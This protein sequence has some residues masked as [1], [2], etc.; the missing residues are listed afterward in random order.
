MKKIL[1][2]IIVLAVTLSIMPLAS[3]C[4]NAYLDKAPDSGLSEEEVFSKY[5]N[6]KSFFYA[7]YTGTNS[8]LRAFHPL[9]FAFNNKKFTFEGI[10]DMCDMARLTDSQ[11]IKM[12]NGNN[13]IW[14]VGYNTTGGGNKEAAKVTYA[15]RILRICN[16]AI[17]KID[18]LQ[19]A[20]E[21]QKED[22]LGQAYFVRAYVN[23]EIFRF[24][25]AIPYVDKVLGPNDEWDLPAIGENEF[26]HK[27]ADDFQTASVHFEKAGLMRRDPASGAGHLAAP[28]QDKPNGV[29][30]LAMKGRALLY[31]ASPLNNPD[32]NKAIWEEAAVA[33]MEAIKAAEKYGYSLLPLS[34][35]S[36]NYYG[37]NYSNEQLWGFSAGTMQYKNS[38]LQAFVGYVFTKDAYS[39][40]QCPTQNFVDRFETKDGYA[41]NTEAD[42]SVAEKAGRYNEQNPFVNRDPRLDICIVYNQKDISSGGY[43]KASLYVN[44]NGSLPSG[45]LLQ[46]KSG[47]S[48]GVTETYYY[49]CKRIGGPYQATQNVTLTDPIIRLGELYLNYAE[50][51]FEAYGSYDG[52]VPGSSITS[53]DA[54]DIIRNRAGMPGIREE[55]LASPEVYRMRIKNERAVELCFEGYHYY[56]DIRRWKD[57]P[58]IGR[59]KLYGLR[60]TKL[61]AGYDSSK[62]PTGFRYDRFELPANRQIAWKNDG[63]YYIQF[64]NKDL[65]K[66]KNYTPKMAW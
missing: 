65:I 34:E 53:Q 48:D 14:I 63:M 47:S 13:A 6:Y 39:S 58:E 17:D 30:A 35:Y 12:G 51:A 40:A 11:S 21:Q 16:I 46:K 41:L 15:W 37:N 28:D 10:T 55:Y 22:L 44:E 2:H 57:A 18:K 3:S 32:G 4:L 9:T 26:L 52:K 60:A 42:R 64:D 8:K 7:V 29:A 20:T 36:K 38:F 50:A 49:E 66:M 62:Y 23:F 54:L 5:Q 24:Y 33:N 59:S 61:N 25:G 45:S 43:G 1:R 19:D 31:A 27:V 56:C